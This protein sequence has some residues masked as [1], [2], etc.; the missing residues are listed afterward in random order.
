[1]IVAAQTPNYPRALV[2]D[3]GTAPA[4]RFGFA[5][6][7]FGD[8][9]TAIRGG[10]GLLY[11][12]PLG[13]DYPANYTYPLV[14]N[15]LVEYGTISTFRQAQGFI[16]PPAVIGYD[17][18]MKAEDVFNVSLTVQRNIGFGTLVDVGY[19]GSFGRHLSWAYGLNNVPLGAQ[20]QKSNADPTNPSVP[21]PTQLLEP[22]HRLHR[23]F[24]QRRRLLLQLPFAAGNRAA[25]LRQRRPVRPRI[26][27][28]EGYG[29]GRH[30][31]CRRQQ[32][33]AV[34]PVPRSGITDWRGF[35]RTNIVKVKL[36]VGRSRK[37][38]ASFMPARAAVNGWRPLG[39]YTYS[40]GAPTLI[41]LPRKPRR[42]I[43]AARPASA[44]ASR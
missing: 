30:R 19:A 41:G 26:H 21:L 10:F 16:S 15:P 11:D 7:P 35:D 20:F 31:F 24:V 13:I 39:I 38:N 37:W 18:N 2:N 33:R 36:A 27:L 25:P 44:R 9:K 40:S 4:P 1:M 5:Y 29:L 28:V 14:Q 34:E 6:D 17:R 23:H 3:F 12:R 32:R 8:G 22:D 42:P 43:S